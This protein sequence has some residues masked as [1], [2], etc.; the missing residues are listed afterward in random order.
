V[1]LLIETLKSE[2]G[3]KIHRKN[4]QHSLLYCLEETNDKAVA[5]YL[6]KAKYPGRII[7]F[8]PAKEYRLYQRPE[9]G[10]EDLAAQGVELH[11]LNVYP[12]QMLAEPFVRDLAEKLKVYVEEAAKAIKD[13]KMV[14]TPTDGSGK[15]DANL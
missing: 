10:W 7:Q 6:P 8:L 3:F 11:T 5:K 14:V 12:R 1:A 13:K 2:G 15:P 4:G 9:L